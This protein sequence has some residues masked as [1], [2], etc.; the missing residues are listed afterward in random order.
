MKKAKSTAKYSNFVKKMFFNYS[1]VAEEEIAKQF[2]T[3]RRE[4]IIWAI[5]MTEKWPF[6]FWTVTGDN[7][8]LYCT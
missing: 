7:L 3:E 4:M 2:P 8:Y 1:N 5:H 6:W